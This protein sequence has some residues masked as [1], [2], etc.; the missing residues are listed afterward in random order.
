VIDGDTI[1]VHG[2]RICLH[3]IDAP[4]NSQRCINAKRVSYSCGQKAA[5]AL[6]DKI[7]RRMVFCEPRDMDRYKRAVAVCRLSG[8]CWFGEFTEPSE[9]RRTRGRYRL[10]VTVF[11]I[12]L[13]H[14]NSVEAFDVH[15]ALP[16]CLIGQ[17]QR[18]NSSTRVTAASDLDR[19]ISRQVPST[20]SLHLLPALDL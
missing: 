13:D 6:S 12:G 15:F 14:F 3:G 20:T 1:E 18:F 10:E 8:T 2:Q 4:E 16:I 9:W 11:D 5:L 19:V 7:G 17:S